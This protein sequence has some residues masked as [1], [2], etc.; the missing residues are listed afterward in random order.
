V[1]ID[2]QRNSRR[3]QLASW[4][5]VKRK[6]AVGSRLILLRTMQKTRKSCEDEAFN[7]TMNEVRKFFSSNLAKAVEVM[8]IP[9]KKKKKKGPCDV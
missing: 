5:K 8:M 3:Y 6:K 7:L 4:A 9:K 1:P 2:P